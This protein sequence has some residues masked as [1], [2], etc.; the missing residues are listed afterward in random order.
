MPINKIEAIEIIE[1]TI[2]VSHDD[3][4]KIFKKA[5]TGR[6]FNSDNEIGNWL[7]NRLFYNGLLK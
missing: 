6:E 7:E 4:I 1:N 5:E 3:A 2:H